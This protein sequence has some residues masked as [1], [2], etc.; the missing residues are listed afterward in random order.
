M[1]YDPAKPY[2]KNIGRK[3]LGYTKFCIRNISCCIEREI[4]RNDFAL[5]RSDNLLKASFMIVNNVKQLV[6]A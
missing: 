1:S 6:D 4:L 2:E 3:R 5:P